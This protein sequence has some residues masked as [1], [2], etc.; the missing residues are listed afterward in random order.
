MVGFMCG[1]IDGSDDGG[2]GSDDGGN[3]SDMM[4]VMVMMV[5]VGDYDGDDTADGGGSYNAGDNDD[6]NNDVVFKHPISKCSAT[7]TT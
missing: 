5:M 3:G 4:V 2:D 7:M 6:T 1:S